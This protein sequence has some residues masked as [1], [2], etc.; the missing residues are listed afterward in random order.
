MTATRPEL[1]HLRSGRRRLPSLPKSPRITL[2]SLHV[3]VEWCHK[4][5]GSFARLQLD[6]GG[7]ASRAGLSTAR[8]AETPQV[9]RVGIGLPFLEGLEVSEAHRQEHLAS[10][11]PRPRFL[12]LD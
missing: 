2:P 3:E 5:G 8:K 10:V 1:R 4:R 9:D 7:A 12:L 11:I 6:R